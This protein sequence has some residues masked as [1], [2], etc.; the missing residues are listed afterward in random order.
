MEINYFVVFDQLKEYQKRATSIQK[1]VAFSDIL[2][3]INPDTVFSYD[4]IGM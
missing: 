4:D 1:S 3:S 2:H